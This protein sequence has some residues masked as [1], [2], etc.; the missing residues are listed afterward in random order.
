MAQTFVRTGISLG[1]WPTGVLREISEP[2]VMDLKDLCSFCEGVEADD[3]VFERCSSKTQSGAVGFRASEV[4]DRVALY[5]LAVISALIPFRNS[6]LSDRSDRKKASPLIKNFFP[7]RRYKQEWLACF[8]KAQAT[9][10]FKP[11]QEGAEVKKRK[12]RK[13][14]LRSETLHELQSLEKAAGGLQQE[15]YGMEWSCIPC[16]QQPTW[17]CYC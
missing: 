13:L 6:G 12:S 16:A 11:F 15:T 10:V 7:S 8:R 4:I 9:D 14:Q 2:D 3:I 1:R 17:T 5:D